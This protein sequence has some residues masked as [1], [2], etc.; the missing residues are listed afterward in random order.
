MYTKV[1]WQADTL[2]TPARFRQMETQ[3]DEVIA[4]W[5][6]NSFR[7]LTGEELVVEV[8]DFHID[9]PDEDM[10]RLVFDESTGTLWVADGSDWI[11]LEV[12]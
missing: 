11:D 8:V 10:G 6:T 3:Y 5:A 12:A 4:Y 9:I 2:L 1:N 7:L